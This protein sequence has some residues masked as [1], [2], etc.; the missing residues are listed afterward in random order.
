M[1]Q[2]LLSNAIRYTQDGGVLLAC[3]VRGHQ[4]LLQV[5]DTGPGIPR[6]EH[7]RIFDE[8]YQARLPGTDGRD[9]K[10]LGLGLAIVKRL[11]ALQGAQMGLHSQVG[12][13]TAFELTVP[14]GNPAMARSARAAR[15]MSASLS[16]NGL[17]IVV[18]EDDASVRE[19]LDVL[20]TGWGARVLGFESMADVQRWTSEPC[21]PD[22]R[23][24]LL[25]VDYRL[26]ADANG[27]DA[28]ERIRAHAGERV[29]AILVSGSTME[30]LGDR[31]ERLDFHVLAK[32]VM[33]ARL[34]AM[35]S[36][37]LGLRESAPLGASGARS[38]FQVV[39]QPG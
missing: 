6:S 31:S 36:F 12:R 33:P 28:M 11:V 38:E 8:F 21:A 35:I 34:R 23:P 27:L 14:R 18:V 9:R 39:D 20:L 32:P 5:W 13:G 3:R 29:P 2:N 4:L 15:G 24:D 1:L 26:E 19:A 7:E 16:L 25:I 22:M 37:K 17:L 30:S 10:G